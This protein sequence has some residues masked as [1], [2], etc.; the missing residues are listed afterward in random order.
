MAD[1]VCGC[2]WCLFHYT[3][4]RPMFRTVTARQTR[5]NRG[6]IDAQTLSDGGEIG[7]GNLEMTAP[8][9][10]APVRP[11]AREREGF[12]QRPDRYGFK[13]NPGDVPPPRPKIW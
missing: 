5:S 8:K 6:R 1:R 11:A 9:H 10:V 2:L 4:G 7:P 3:T 12:E 13:R